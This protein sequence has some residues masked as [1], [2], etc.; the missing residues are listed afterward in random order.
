[1]I[2]YQSSTWSTWLL[3]SFLN[4]IVILY[5]FH[6]Q[7][8]FSPNISQLTIHCL[9]RG[10]L[11]YVAEFVAKEVLKRIKWRKELVESDSCNS[12]YLVIN[13]RAYSVKPLLAPSTN[14]NKFLQKY[15]SIL[16]EVIFQIC[17]K[18][19]I[20]LLLKTV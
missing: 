18:S 13:T 5:Y 11:T 16:R 19:N 7:K 12:E 4:L 15:I 1:M 10:K 20:T 3:L 9:K 6:F 8:F 17:H 14:F 2:I